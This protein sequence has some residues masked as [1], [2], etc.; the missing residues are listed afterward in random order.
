MQSETKMA[1]R[2]PIGLILGVAAPVFVL[3]I[4]GTIPGL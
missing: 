1:W 4:F 2:V 3:V